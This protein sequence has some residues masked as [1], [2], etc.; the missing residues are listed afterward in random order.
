MNEICRVVMMACVGLLGL[1]PL[2]QAQGTLAD[3]QR[4]D[5][6]RA[7]TAD[8]VFKSS[9]KPHW[10]AGDAAFCNGNDLPRGAFREFIAVK[11]IRN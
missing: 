10:S 6:L 5:S 2:V 8:K 7:L 4:A 1:A 11:A 9:V 3:Y